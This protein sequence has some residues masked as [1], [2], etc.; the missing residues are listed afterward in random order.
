VVERGEDRVDQ[1]LDVDEVPLHRHVVRVEHYRHRARF[2]VAVRLLRRRRGR[3][4][5]GPPKT[6]SPNE[7]WYRKSSFSM[8]HGARRQQ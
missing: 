6:S 7:S 3:A 1:V 4:S 5:T 2:D 8:I